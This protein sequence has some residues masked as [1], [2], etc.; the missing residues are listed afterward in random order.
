MQP[1]SPAQS[2]DRS[3]LYASPQSSS[4]LPDFFGAL[5]A[6]LTLVLPF[7]LISQYSMTVDLK[8]PTVPTIV[9]PVPTSS[10]PLLAPEN[11]TAQDG[12]TGG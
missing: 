4:A 2:P 11:R 1:G 3:L 10:H 7:V 12:Q 9:V 6:M 5:I 8:S